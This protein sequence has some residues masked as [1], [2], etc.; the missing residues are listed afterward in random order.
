ME[1]VLF[2]SS[3]DWK[4]SRALRIGGSLVPLAACIEK[5]ICFPLIGGS[6][7][8]YGSWVQVIKFD[9]FDQIAF[10]IQ[11]NCQ[12]PLL[13]SFKLLNLRKVKINI[14]FWKRIWWTPV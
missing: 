3:I 10:I 7:W 2:G 13:A 14:I 6:F 1:L 8:D 4:T 5:L 11:I 12:F 9:R